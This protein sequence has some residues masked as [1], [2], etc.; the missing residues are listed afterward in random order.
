VIAAAV[1]DA[2]P[3]TRVAAVA[4]TQLP[5]TGE[6]AGRPDALGQLPSALLAGA[7]VVAIAG[8]IAMKRRI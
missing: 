3:S 2:S 1:A 5:R 6:G 7:G 4:G 8:A